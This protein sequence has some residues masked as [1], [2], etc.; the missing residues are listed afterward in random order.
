MVSLSLYHWKVFCRGYID[1]LKKQ[2]D[3]YLAM[4]PYNFCVTLTLTLDIGPVWVPIYQMVGW[5]SRKWSVSKNDFIFTLRFWENPYNKPQWKYSNILN[6]RPNAIYQRL[7]LI[8]Y[9]MSHWKHF[10]KGFIKGLS[11]RQT[12]KVNSSIYEVIVI[13]AFGRRGNCYSGLWPQG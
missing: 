8:L 9:C 11:K 3:Q 10:Q 2:L 12:T 13:V 6:P 4:V 1:I 5:L 7:Y